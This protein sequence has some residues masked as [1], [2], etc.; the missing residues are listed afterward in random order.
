MQRAG[1]NPI[2]ESPVTLA[3]NGTGLVGPDGKAI[4]LGG[5]S[6]PAVTNSGLNRASSAN[7]YTFKVAGYAFPGRC[8]HVAALRR[9]F[10]VRN[11]TPRV[12]QL[13]FSAALNDNA[14]IGPANWFD[15]PP[16]SEYINWGDKRQCFIRPKLLP[17]SALTSSGTTATATLANHGL[18]TGDSVSIQGATPSGYN[19]GRDVVTVIDANTFTYPLSAAQAACTIL[20][21]MGDLSKTVE[22]EFEEA[23]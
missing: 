19:L 20:P 3:A 4:A 23:L 8:V 15:L 13:T 14:N 5:G 12:M 1:L 7:W 6:A 21:G 17:L 2:G 9:Y 18:V 10:I 11:T 22:V 16:G